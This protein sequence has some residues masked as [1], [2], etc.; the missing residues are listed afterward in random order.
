[1]KNSLP[2]FASGKVVKGFGRGSK[3][4]GTPTANFNQSIVDQLPKDLPT[5]IY[6]GWAQV[7]SHVVYPMVTSVGWNPYF[8]NKTKSMVN[9]LSLN[10]S[11][12]S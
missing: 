2:Y 12:P 9:P 10:C 6:F 4:L 5:G 11:F 7:N 3:S 8:G 1:M